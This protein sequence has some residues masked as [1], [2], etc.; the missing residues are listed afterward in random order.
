MLLKRVADRHRGDKKDYLHCIIYHRAIYNSSLINSYH[1]A[2][3]N[4]FSAEV[5]PKPSAVNSLYY[6]GGD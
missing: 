3:E 5:K 1:F 4:Y 6:I 2:F